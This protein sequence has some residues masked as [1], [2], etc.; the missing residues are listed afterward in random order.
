WTEVLVADIGLKLILEQVSPVIPNNYEVTSFPVC[1]FYWTVINNSKVDFKVTLT[2]TFRNGT[3]NP[4]WDHEG[5]CSAEPLQISSAKGLKLKHTI[6]SMPTTFA[7]AA[8]QMAGATLS[9]ATFNPASTGDDI[10][11][12]LQSSGSLSGGM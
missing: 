1:N 8:E 4:K 6:K 12:S 10:W 5:Q 3:G 11:R 2:F 7:V 9:Y